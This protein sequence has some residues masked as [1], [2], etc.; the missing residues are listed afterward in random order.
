MTVLPVPQIPTQV[1][2]YTNSVPPAGLAVLEKPHRVLPPAG[3]DGSGLPPDKITPFSGIYGADGKL[4][5]I[6]TKGLTF[7]AYA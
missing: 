5:T 2:R 3:M 6:P 4:P 7:L 1:Q